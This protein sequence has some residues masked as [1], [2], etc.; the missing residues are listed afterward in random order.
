MQA[1]AGMKAESNSRNESRKQQQDSQHCMVDSKSR[2]AVKTKDDNSSRDN[3][4]IMD[5]ISSGTARIDC[6]VNSNIQQGHQ[7]K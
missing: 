1:T 6:R 7:Q 4:I 2:N 3:N 5:I